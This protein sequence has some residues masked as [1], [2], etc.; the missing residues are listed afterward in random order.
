[1]EVI[2]HTEVV[3]TP[4]SSNFSN[5]GV[6]ALGVSINSNS[7]SEPLTLWGLEDMIDTSH[8]DYG[9]GTSIIQRK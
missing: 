4:Q 8:V 7:L 2:Q 3:L 5:V 6:G 1:M 9:D